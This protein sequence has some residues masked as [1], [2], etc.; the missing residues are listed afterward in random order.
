MKPIVITNFKTYKEATGKNAVKLAKAHEKIMNKVNVFVAVQAADI[1]RVS[2]NTKVKVIAQHVD[3]EEYGKH[4]GKIIPEDIKDD[5]AVGSLINHA[6]DR[7]SFKVIKK[8]IE[9]CKKLKLKTIVC[10]ENVGKAKK[11]AKFKPDY[12]AFEYPKLI[13]TLNSISKV[14]PDEVKKFAKIINKT[15]SIPLCGAGV[16]DNNDFRLALKLGTKG[17]LLATAIV[18]AKNP[19]KALK[20]LVK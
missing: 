19:E 5:G 14:K 3:Y 2:K 10:V 13:G 11:I 4:T 6:E 9:R 1:Y 20:E 17:V 12:I 18:K 16:A 7:A 8:T 15:K